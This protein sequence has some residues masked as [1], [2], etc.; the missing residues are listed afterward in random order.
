MQTVTA[1]RLPRALWTL[2]LA[3]STAA[4]TFGAAT[5]PVQ[6]AAPGAYSAV[7]AAPLTAPRRE[8]VDGTIWRCAGDRCSAPADGARPLAICGKVMHRFGTVARFSSPQGDL[9]S[10]QLTR[11]NAN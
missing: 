8:I 6:A 11:C 9:S 3:L 4:G 5:A 10:E 1:R 2:A 7:L